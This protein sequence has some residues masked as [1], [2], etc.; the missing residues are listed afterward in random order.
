MHTQYQAALTFAEQAHQGQTYPSHLQGE[1]EDYIRHVL[2]VAELVEAT[3]QGDTAYDTSLAVH[4]ALLHDTLEDTLVTAAELE[5]RFGKAIT[6]GVQ[7]LSKNPDLPKPEQMLD[8]LARI[9]QQ[10]HEV[11]LV[12]LADRISNLAPP[13]WHWDREKIIAYQEESRIIHAQLQDAHAGLAASL[14]ERI[15]DYGQ[16]IPKGDE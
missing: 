1:E 5:S 13:P 2:E 14:L 11:W 7:A 16:Y 6:A 15:T 12:K 8:S 4:C 10:P 3:L 9:R